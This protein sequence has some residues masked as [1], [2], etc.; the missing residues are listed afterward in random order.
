MLT[1][2][3][4]AEAR[5]WGEDG[6]RIVCAIALNLLDPDDKVEVDRLTATYETPDGWSYR[7]FTSACVFADTARRNARNERPGWNHFAEYAAWHFLNLPRSRHDIHASD[8]GGDCV[9]HGIEHHLARFRDAGLR[10]GA[11]A[12]A[13]FFLAHWIG[14]V[15]QPLHV[16]YADDLGGNRTPVTGAYYEPIDRLHGVWDTGIIRKA[17]G[18]TGWWAYALDLEGDIA[19]A[20]RALWLETDPSDWAQQS[21]DMT[22]RDEVD[23]CRWSE[24]SCRREFHERR[25]DG[26]YQ[27]LFVD[28][29]VERLQQAGVR[30]AALIED[31]LRP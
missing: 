13:L 4:V 12:E 31:G 25:L 20:D 9:L 22:T 18:T 11:R 30:L 23:Y 28:A 27:A 2:L 7:Y 16:S 15:H 14:D 24:G 26:S 17:R 29:V 21:Y 8:C 19:P 5:A 6:H 1:T 10:D 3:S